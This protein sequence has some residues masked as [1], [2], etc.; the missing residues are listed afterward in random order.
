MNQQAK[1]DLLQN[2][3]DRAGT[4]STIFVGQRPHSDWHEFIDD[5]LI[6]DAV[7]D[8]LSRNRYHIKLKS[9]SQRRS[10]ARLDDGAG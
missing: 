1:S 8:R 6:A 4:G 2:L 7:L 3:D 5:P 10:D 9:D